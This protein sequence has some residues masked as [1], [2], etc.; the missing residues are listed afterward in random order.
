MQLFL[1][2][3]V[4]ALAISLLLYLL[5]VFSDH[6]R[7]RGAGLLYPPGPTPWPVIGNLLDVPKN[8][9]WIAYSNMSKK[10]GRDIILGNWLA[11]V[12]TRVSRR[13]YLSSHFFTGHRRLVVH[14]SH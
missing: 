8:A 1:I 14:I 4:G 6:R 13:C 2:N 10:Y 9:P 5:V 11:P 7:R 3:T 12:D